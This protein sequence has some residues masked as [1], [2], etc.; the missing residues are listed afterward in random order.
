MKNPLPVTL[1]DLQAT[2]K[3]DRDGKTT[4]RKITVKW[5]PAR[6]TFIYEHDGWVCRKDFAIDILAAYSTLY[7]RRGK[8][9]PA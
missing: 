4:Y 6:N 9:R 8:T 2:A 5:I 1:D 7:Q 3:D